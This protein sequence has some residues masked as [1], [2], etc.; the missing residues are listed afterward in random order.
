MCCCWLFFFCMWILFHFARFIFIFIGI[1]C[2]YTY[3]LDSLSKPTFCS[4]PH[5]HIFCTLR[6]FLNEFQ[7]HC[8]IESKCCS[9]KT[10]D[11]EKSQPNSPNVINY[12]AFMLHAYL[13]NFITFISIYHFHVYIMCILSCSFVQRLIK[14]QTCTNILLYIIP[15]YAHSLLCVFVYGSEVQHVGLGA[16]VNHFYYYYYYYCLVHINPHLL[17]FFKWTNQIRSYTRF[18]SK[19]KFC[20]NQLYRIKPFRFSFEKGIIPPIDDIYLL[21]IYLFMNPKFDAFKWLIP[22]Y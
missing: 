22:F 16:G 2:A 10:R 19:V 13:F 3:F 11:V 17:L 6:V 20:M 12:T 7:I 18:G 4:L 15:R 8:Y 14:C 1:F 5:R 21:F 9:S